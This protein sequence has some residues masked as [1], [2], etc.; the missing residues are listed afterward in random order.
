MK[1][2]TLSRALVLGAASVPALTAVS[3][4]KTP[5]RKPNVIFILMDDACLLYTSPSPRD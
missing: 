2:S 3:C 5:E 4:D 1:T